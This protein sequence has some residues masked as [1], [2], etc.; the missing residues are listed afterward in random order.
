MREEGGECWWG[1]C[2][3][4]DG[5][6]SSNRCAKNGNQS[7]LLKCTR[8]CFLFNKH[9]FPE[10]DKILEVTL[11]LNTMHFQGLFR[12]AILESGTELA[13][14]VMHTPAQNPEN[15]LRQVHLC[16]P[17]MSPQVYI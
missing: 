16:V 9:F 3:P 10:F 15:Y 1:E 14:W 8:L 11:A 7:V 13:P 2:R 4:A 12:S 6:T 17:D 5:V